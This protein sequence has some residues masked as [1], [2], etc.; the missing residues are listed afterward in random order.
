MSV[1][2]DED[3]DDE[4]WTGE[5]GGSSSSSDSRAQTLTKDDVF[6]I[7]QNPRRR[8]VLR[9]VLE[10]DDQEQFDMRDIAEEVAAWKYDT[11]VEELSSDERQRVYISLYQSHLPQ[12][13]THGIIEYNQDRGLVRATALTTM[14]APYLEDGLHADSEYLDDT[15]NPAPVEDQSTRKTTFSSLLTKLRE[16]GP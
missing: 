1:K 8:A 10:H 4:D 6:H 16:F 11:T 9:Y 13:D 5:C 2:G 12:L 7:L 15:S 14:L 3:C